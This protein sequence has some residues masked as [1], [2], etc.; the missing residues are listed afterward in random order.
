MFNSTPIPGQQASAYHRAA[1][2]APVRPY[3]TSATRAC[4]K[5]S[6]VLHRVSRDTQHRRERRLHGAFLPR[7][8][9]VANS[10]LLSMQLKKEHGEKH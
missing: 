5:A 8:E 6:F 7:L 10:G 4:I 3:V 1:L 2:C 9:P